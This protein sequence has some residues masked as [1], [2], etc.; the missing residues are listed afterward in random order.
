M[1][2]IRER[3]FLL[4]KVFFGIG[5]VVRLATIAGRL[6]NGDRFNLGNGY[7][8]G[9]PTAQYLTWNGTLIEGAAVTPDLQVPLDPEAPCSK[10]EIRSLRMQ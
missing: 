5:I 7:L 6:L 10:V 8:L 3:Q 4:S 9:L 1:S 2:R